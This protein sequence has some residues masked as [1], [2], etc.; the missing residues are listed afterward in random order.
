MDNY[1]IPYKFDKNEHFQTWLDAQLTR[2][3]FSN[4]KE[5]EAIY[6]DVY[7]RRFLSLIWHRAQIYSFYPTATNESAKAK[8][9]SLFTTY[10]SASSRD[11]WTV[12][13]LSLTALK[14]SCIS[15]PKSSQSRVKAFDRCS[16]AENQ[17]E[18]IF[19]YCSSITQTYASHCFNQSYYPCAP[20]KRY[21]SLVFDF[22]PPS[23]RPLL[24]W[25]ISSPSFTAS[26]SFSIHILS[27]VTPLYQNYTQH[28]FVHL[29]FVSL[30]IFI[31]SSATCQQEAHMKFE[32]FIAKIIVE[33]MA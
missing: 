3:T 21:A 5:E 13:T 4:P 6:Q 16:A 22:S 28:S 25:L 27:L 14:K 33:R 24:F 19:Y 11:R 31:S 20:T 1:L 12:P 23:R 15:S 29:T 26:H 30:Y 9:S 17:P 32:D 18:M 8:N 2:F 7:D 10:G